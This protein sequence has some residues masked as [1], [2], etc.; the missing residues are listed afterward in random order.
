MFQKSRHTLQ[1]GRIRRSGRQ[2][3]HIDLLLEVPCTLPTIG[4]KLTT[5]VLERN[6]QK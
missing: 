4:S 3:Q 5:F 1:I 2:T 6:R